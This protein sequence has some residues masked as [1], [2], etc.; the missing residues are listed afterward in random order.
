MS[1]KRVTIKDLAEELSVSTATV[2]LVLS[3]R[4]EE[5]R[6]SDETRI[7]IE[8]ATERLGY[9]PDRLAR[10]MR[11]GRSDTIGVV[12]PDMTESFMNHVLEGIEEVANQKK[13]SLMIAT[14]SLDYKVEARNLESLQD[15]R[16]DGLLI[17][18]YAPFNHEK[19]SD[20]VVKRVARSATPIVV[21]DRMIPGIDTCAVLGNDRAAA[22]GAT[23]RLLDKG[24]RKPA[25]VGLDINISTLQERRGGFYSTVENAGLADVVRECLIRRRDPESD[26]L[27]NWLKESIAAGTLP[28]GFLVSTNGLALKLRKLL[29]ELTGRPPGD[30]LYRIARFGEDSEYFPTGMMEVV[31]PHKE[32]G[33][34]AT[35]K[36]FKKI[37]GATIPEDQRIERLD[38]EIRNETQ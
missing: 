8:E 9:R 30:G 13:T 19:Y 17:I 5:Y 20:R 6:I 25:Y 1:G 23:A 31:Q 28:D 34:R 2:S 32:I 11:V 35:R 36:L 4:G 27:R 7:R 16:V 10:S 14:S 37:S 26:D 18:P 29:I 3:G 38:M 22:A 24:C 12:F 33:R 15:R 21:L